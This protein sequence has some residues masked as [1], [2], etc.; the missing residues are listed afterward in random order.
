MQWALS[1]GANIV[2]EKSQTCTLTLNS[3]GGLIT[4][5]PESQPGLRKRFI[6]LILY[7]SLGSCPQRHSVMILCVEHLKGLGFRRPGS[8]GCCLLHEA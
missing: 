3:E 8:V 1:F 4:L 5:F 7:E 2:C 6:V